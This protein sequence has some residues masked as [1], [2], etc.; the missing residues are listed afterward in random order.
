M[1]FNRILGAIIMKMLNRKI[2]V[3]LFLNLEPF[4][5]LYTLSNTILADVYWFD[6]TMHNKYLFIWV[7]VIVLVIAKKNI[8]SIFI[9]YGNVLGIVLGQ[10]LGDPIQ[11]SNIKL[12]S[13]IMTAEEVAKAYHHPAFEIWF[14]TI[15]ICVIT[16]IIVNA[17]LERKQVKK[18]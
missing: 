16:S 11:A 18:V 6:W 15:F 5:I 14:T 12:I 9:A 17:I 1:V 8:M 7:G 4:V 13:D 10:Y 2:F 3:L